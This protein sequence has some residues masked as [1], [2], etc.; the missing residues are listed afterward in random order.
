MA[1][2]ISVLGKVQGMEGWP[3][4]SHRVG[5]WG[6]E[7]DPSDVVDPF[8]LPGGGVSCGFVS[9]PGIPWSMAVGGPPSLAV[10]VA[11]GSLEIAWSIGM[12]GLPSLAVSFA[13]GSS[14]TP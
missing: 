10:S 13:K 9:L 12:D 4:L 6:F 14:D 5:C 7:I 2:V 11:E 8:S 1:E 3:Q